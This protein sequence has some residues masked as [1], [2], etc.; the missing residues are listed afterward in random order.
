M[1]RTFPLWLGLA[2]LVGTGL[3]HGLWTDRWQGSQELADAVARLERVPDRLGP[4]QATAVPL[5]AEVLA[6]AGAAGQRSLHFTH[7]R[8]GEQVLVILLCGKP[9]PISV[10][11]PEHCYRGAGY[12]MTAPAAKERLPAIAP[13][14][15]AEFWTARFRK[16][17]ETQTVQL[18]IFWSWF[19]GGSWQAPGSPR[20]TFARYP[21]LYKLYVIR[22]TTPGRERLDRDADRKFLNQVMPVLTRALTPP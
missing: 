22:E 19:A 20:W 2:V 15:P 14:P 1:Y 18:R 4:W 17:E 21:A 3:V 5:E 7:R 11:R 12:E 16:Q 6:Q 10:H 13:G 8:T 9:G